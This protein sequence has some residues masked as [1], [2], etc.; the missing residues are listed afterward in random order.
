VA[1]LRAINV[2]GRNLVS[3]A[4]LAA[5]FV[6]AGC[7]DVR[8]YIQSGNVVFGATPG[9]AGRVARVVSTALEERFGFSAPVV[10]RTGE[11]VAAVA[12]GNPFLGTGADPAHLH[13]AFL[14]EAPGAARAASLDP[15]RSP[16]DSFV[17]RG[18]GV[19]LHLPG[20]VAKSKLTSAYLDKALGT[21]STARNW[22]T[23]LKLAEMAGAARA[24]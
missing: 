17:V 1:L 13:V 2:G 6:D 12:A 5:I 23:V 14:A 11:E 10:V 4:D 22:R 7:A 24:G 20:G 18:R 19:Y 3:M 8:T 21:V 15:A 16:G 9:C